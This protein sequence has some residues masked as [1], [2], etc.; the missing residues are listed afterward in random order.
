[1]SK[2]WGPMRMQ[3]RDQYEQFFAA[4]T[5]NAFPDR[6]ARYPEDVQCLT[7]VMITAAL[8]MYMTP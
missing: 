8:W 3:T 6:Y 4:F 2:Q 5:G 1:M 7:D